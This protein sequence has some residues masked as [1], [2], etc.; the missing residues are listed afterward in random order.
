MGHRYPIRAVATVND[1]VSFLFRFVSNMLNENSL[2]LHDVLLD[3]SARLGAAARDRKSPMHTPVIGTA[4]GDLRVMVLRA[5]DPD[6]AALR[7]HTDA[8]SPKAALIAERPEMALLAYDPAAKVQIR[9]RGLGRIEREG[10]VADAA[11]VAATPF[12]R[13][14]YLTSAGPGSAADGPLS[15]L[16]PELEGVCPTEEQLLAARDNFAVLLITLTEL[17]WLY[18]AHNGHRRAKFSRGDAGQPWQGTWV[19]P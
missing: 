13:R 8:R 19:V 2:G 12:A 1:L 14:C 11:W 17:D 15:G 16:P 6:L 7:L 10:S 3:V 18:L 4:D 5:C 9:A